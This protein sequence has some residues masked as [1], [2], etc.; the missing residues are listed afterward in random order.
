MTPKEKAKEL[1]EKFYYAT[2]SILADKKQDLT[3]KKGA[4]ICV[5]E[6]LQDYA[7]YRLK[8]YFTLSQAIEL[9]EYWAEVKQEIKKL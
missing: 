3:A 5:D 1:Y 6:I 9:S 8:S 4:L 7:S 2:P